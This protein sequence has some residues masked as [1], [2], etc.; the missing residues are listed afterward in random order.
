MTLLSRLARLFRANLYGSYSDRPASAEREFWQDAAAGA[1]ANPPGY[2][3]VLAR[4]YA[5]LELPYGADLVKVRQAWKNLLRKY[6]PDLHSHDPE[7]RR[8]A[9]ELAQGLNRAYEE[10]EKR[11]TPH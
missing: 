4:Y 5:N 3:P 2:D 11:L 7:K 1:Q 10:L 8:V 6:H 9:T